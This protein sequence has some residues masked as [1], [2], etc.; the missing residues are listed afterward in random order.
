M[1]EGHVIAVRI[2]RFSD[3]CDQLFSGSGRVALRSRLPLKLSVEEVTECQKGQ[4]S[5]VM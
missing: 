1:L 3:G 4:I 2:V 5:G